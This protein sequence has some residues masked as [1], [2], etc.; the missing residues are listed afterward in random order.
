MAL[1]SQPAQHPL[2]ASPWRVKSDQGRSVAAVAGMGRLHQQCACGLG[3]ASCAVICFSPS[4]PLI[5]RV[6]QRASLAALRGSAAGTYLPAR[7]FPSVISGSSLSW[8]PMRAHHASFNKPVALVRLTARASNE[9]TQSKL[10][11]CWLV[12]CA[13]ATHYRN[14]SQSHSLLSWLLTMLAFIITNITSL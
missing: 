3:L 6:L 9:A 7:L 13:R 2:A 4:L 8:D 1:Y 14:Y 11:V 12:R 5:H 10:V